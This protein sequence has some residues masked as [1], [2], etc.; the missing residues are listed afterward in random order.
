MLFM[1]QLP[2]AIWNGLD[3]STTPF[4]VTKYDNEAIFTGS[5][6]VFEGGGPGGKGKGIV[7]I[8]PG[9]CNKKDWPACSTGT[10]LAQA[11]PADY[12]ND[13]LLLN[14]TKPSYNPIMEGTQRDPSSPWKT[15]G[16]FPR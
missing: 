11:V 2:T 16:A 1:L 14:W 3:S 15:P 5:A 7:N 13:E 12:A 9:L 6:Q 4:T 8:Y 10:L